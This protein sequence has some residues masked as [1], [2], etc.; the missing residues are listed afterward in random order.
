MGGEP[1]PRVTELGYGCG[2]LDP[3]T[4]LY[5]WYEDVPDVARGGS[6][7]LAWSEVFDQWPLIEACFHLHYGVD[8]EREVDRRSW[9][10]FR[11]R[12]SH[13]LNSDTALGQHFRAQERP[14]DE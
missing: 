13:L 8:L 12:L 9:R 7:V 11:V 10:W 1:D 6:R 4:G 5:A 2:D 14:D 3:D